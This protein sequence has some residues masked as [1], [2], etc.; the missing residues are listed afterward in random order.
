MRCCI[1]TSNISPTSDGPYMALIL[2][3][4]VTCEGHKLLLPEHVS[5]WP[6]NA[7]KLS[8]KRLDVEVLEIVDTGPF[9]SM[10]PISPLCA[11]S[12]DE[13]TNFKALR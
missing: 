12:D 1:E 5:L 8:A 9:L 3:I 2:P 6:V 11:F 7:A 4:K 13:Y 10:E